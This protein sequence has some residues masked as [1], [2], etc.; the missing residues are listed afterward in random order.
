MGD[1][2]SRGLR[3]CAGCGMLKD[4]RD[5]IRVIRTKEGEI[6]VDETQKKNGRGSY[7]CRS[8]DCLEAAVKRRAFQRE[9]RCSKDPDIYG[10]VRRIIEAGNE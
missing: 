1:A 2:A 3:R 4:K 8:A 9:L 6:L 5:L 7:L 10:Q